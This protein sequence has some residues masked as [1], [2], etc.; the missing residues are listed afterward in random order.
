VERYRAYQ[1]A[2]ELLP[3]SPLVLGR[4]ARNLLSRNERPEALVLAER[5]AQLAPWNAEV[6]AIHA[7][8]LAAAG[9]CVEGT[10][11]AEL[12][13]KLL[14]AGSGAMATVLDV[15][16]ARACP[17]EPPADAGVTTGQR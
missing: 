15:G 12:A 6:L 1:R 7:L 3:D 8:A 17:S 10:S 11:A 2:V 9:R 4:A 14:P 16:L 5:A 13:R